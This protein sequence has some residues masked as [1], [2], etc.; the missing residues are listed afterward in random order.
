VQNLHPFPARMAPQLATEALNTDNAAPLRVLDPMCGSG[1]VLYEAQRMGHQAI[2][3]DSDPLAVLLS[4][5]LLSRVSVDEL[6][7]VGSEVLSDAR[8]A[9]DSSEPSWP[10]NKTKQFVEYWFD[11]EAIRQMRALA[12]SIASKGAATPIQLL[13]WCAFSRMVI[14]KA[15]GVSRAMDL[16]HSRPHRVYEE[17]PSRPFERYSR[18]IELVASRSHKLWSNVDI[19]FKGAICRADARALPVADKSI[20]SI[21]TS[22]PYLNA[23][24]YIRTSKFTLVWLGYPISVL[25]HIRS[26]L[27]GTDSGRGVELSDQVPWHRFGALED[28]QARY[29]RVV[30]RYVDDI[31]AVIDEASRVLRRGGS[32]S[33]VIGNCALRGIYIQNAEI[34]KWAMELNGIQVLSES[35][36][37]IPDNRRYLPPPPE[38]T[39][40][41]RLRQEIVINANKL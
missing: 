31:K 16:S 34:V 28:L 25:S 33:L 29:Q 37:E 9:A 7:Q 24:D 39:A 21:V 12:R 14:V 2:G 20:D 32:M 23:I 38:T 40:P 10:D 1:T 15:G 11:D 41:T 17:G 18:E 5:A 4:R 13:L 35:C 6:R 8:S 27:V 36:R 3:F 26:G 22:P 19:A 30:A